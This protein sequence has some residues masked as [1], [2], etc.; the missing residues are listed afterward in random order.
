[1]NCICELYLN[2]TFI[3][4][5]VRKAGSF[6]CCRNSELE[7]GLETGSSAQQVRETQQG[8][9]DHSDDGHSYHSLLRDY[10]SSPG[11]NTFSIYYIFRYILSHLLKNIDYPHF[12]DEEAEA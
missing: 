3:Y 4:D 5:K 12:T 6:G 9:D 1:M 8:R 7:R 2:K 10:R 11:M